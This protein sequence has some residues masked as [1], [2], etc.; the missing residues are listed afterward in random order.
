MKTT[1]TFI[2]DPR[3]SGQYLKDKMLLNSKPFDRR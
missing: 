2:V 3:K 1:K